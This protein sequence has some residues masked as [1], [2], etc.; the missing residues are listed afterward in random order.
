MIE[1]L[2][3]SEDKALFE[4]FNINL[5]S[6]RHIFEYADSVETAAAIIELELPDYLIIFEKSVDEAFNMINS[7]FQKNEI[8]KIPVLCFLSAAQWS[9]REKLWKAGVKDII[10]LPI[11]KDEVQLI[12]QQFIINMSDVSFD[13]EEAGMYGKLEDYNLLDLIQTLESSK[14]T[15][16][17]VLYRSREEGKIWFYQGNIHDA[18]YRALKPVPAIFKLI[19]WLDGDFSISFVDENYEKLIE[20][21]NQKILLDAIQYID[22]RNK[23]LDS[24][25][26]LNETLLISP[27]ADMDQMNEEEV[28][29]L[30]FFHGGQ[31]ISAYLDLFDEDD[32]SLLEYI[33]KFIEKKMLLT[34]EEFELLTSEQD[35]EAE[36]AGIKKVFKKFF[37]RKEDENTSGSGRRSVSKS[38]EFADEEL[39]EH[40]EK[41]ID[42]LFQ[43]SNLDLERIIQK[44]DNL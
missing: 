37:K 18:K 16:V 3:I 36:N 26:D 13:Q 4:E 30:R 7:L 20:E 29:Y 33:Q 2:V 8:N 44:I 43:S 14:K 23:I 6:E 38:D 27:E 28:T 22:Q 10:Q 15:G 17:L 39:F 24:L 32:R 31:T 1:G 35:R 5:S 41:R 42:S 21:D 12:L 11:A 25:P 34:K 40:L 19:T 9:E